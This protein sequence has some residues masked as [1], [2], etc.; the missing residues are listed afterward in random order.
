MGFLAGENP[1]GGFE[2]G[3][4]TG[5]SESL[6]S[7]IVRETHAHQLLLLLLHSPLLSGLLRLLKTKFRKCKALFI[8]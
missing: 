5:G 6:G 2:D 4:A 1:I 7:Q 8:R 3:I